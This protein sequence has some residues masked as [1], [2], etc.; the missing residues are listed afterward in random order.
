MKGLR[1]WF[2]DEKRPLP[3]RDHPTPYAV[4]VSEVMLQQTQVAVVVPYFE[5]WMSRFP[6]VAAL[7]E[8]DEKE[9]IKLWEGLGYYSRA[10]NLHAGA[11]QLLEKHGGELPSDPTEL[12]K[13]KGIGPYTVGAILS[14]AFKKKAAAV[15]GNVI[16]VITRYLGIEEDIA[17]SS[18][19]QKVKEATF[20]LL[21]DER[22]WEVMEALIELGARV[23]TKTP[24]CFRCPLIKSCAQKTHLPFNSKKQTVTPLTRLVAVVVCE[25]AVLLRQ[26]ASGKVMAGLWEFPY[27]EES[28]PSL[29]ALFQKLPFPIKPLMVLDPL[30]HSFTRFR[31]TLHP[32]LVETPLRSPLEGAEWISLE[33]LSQL[34]FSA[35]HRKVKEACLTFSYAE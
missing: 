7:A 17:K 20:S 12:A 30:V 13:I 21:P 23:C 31:A 33:T 18:T 3:W 35:G 2:L 25:G 27:F 19:L 8:A 29:E 15:D 11:L 16:R 26:V 5:R 10:R 32:Y 14:F 6:T 28:M 9:V 24:Q 4:W 22:P 1:S 34:P